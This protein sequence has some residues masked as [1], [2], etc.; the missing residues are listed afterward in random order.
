MCKTSMQKNRS[1]E[2]PDLSSLF[3]LMSILPSKS[4]KGFWI[5]CK[6]LS[7]Y[8]MIDPDS[9]NEHDDVYNHYAYSKRTT[10]NCRTHVFLKSIPKRLISC[11]FLPWWSIRWFL[12][13]RPKYYIQKRSVFLLIIILRLSSFLSFLLFFTTLLLFFTLLAL[14]SKLR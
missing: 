2:S 13:I 7:V 3:D 8:Y 4:I 11:P 1:N 12:T 14:F 9:N 5:G 6:E 10:S